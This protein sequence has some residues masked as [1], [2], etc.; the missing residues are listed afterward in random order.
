M[1]ERFLEETVPTPCS[2]GRKMNEVSRL[3]S[4][5]E[6][7]FRQ[8]K[9]NLN[10]TNSVH[11]NIMVNSLVFPDSMLISKCKVQFHYLYHRK[12]CNSK[13]QI[14]IFKSISQIILHSI[15]KTLTDINRYG[16]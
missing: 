16:S 10:L 15:S 1:V 6:T 2:R 11:L 12:N 14:L 4:L 3:P 5:I 8:I 9:A 7:N 13:L